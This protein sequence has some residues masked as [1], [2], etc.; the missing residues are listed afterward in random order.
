MQKE[1]RRLGVA[2]IIIL[3]I[4]SSLLC[5][6]L[7]ISV[8]EIPLMDFWK[9][10]G[11]RI[12]RIMSKSLTFNYFLEIPHALQWNPF[13]NLCDIFFIRVFRADN[14]AYVFAGM[15]CSIASLTLLIKIYKE[16][17][18]FNNIVLDALGLM[19]ICL[20]AVNL[21]QWE[22]YTIYFNFSFMFRILMYLL[23][24]YT[25][26]NILRNRTAAKNRYILTLFYAIFNCI[27][28]L[29]VSQAYFIGLI[30]ANTS[31]GIIDYILHKN[32]DNIKLYFMVLLSDI[33]GAVIYFVTLEKNSIAVFSNRSIIQ[34]ITDYLQGILIMLGSVLIPQSIGAN[35]INVCLA[36]GIVIL[37]LSLIAVYAFFKTEMYA[38]TYFPIMCMIYAFIC[39]ATIIPGRRYIFGVEV[40]TSSRYVDDTT[41]GLLGM[42]QIYLFCLKKAFNKLKYTLP[43]TIVLFCIALTLCWTCASEMKTGPYRKIYNLQMA[44]LAKKIDSVSDAELVIFQAP[45]DDV[46]AGIDAM[47]KYHLLLW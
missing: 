41:L 39:I 3:L 30:I 40:L 31:V 34:M 16:K 10:S 24:F 35:N 26:D 18:A 1:N 46:R 37:L 8:G 6:Y 44:E 43:I 14:R 28:I 38:K 33:I 36:L 29:F 42:V 27:I 7:Y 47:K 19:L 15:I 9:G 21:N 45:A 12:E 25:W 17:L 23:M 5:Y 11:N 13:Q 2:D 4:S 22:I 32:R 20:T